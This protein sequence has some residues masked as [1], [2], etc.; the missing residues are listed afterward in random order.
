M[1]EYKICNYCKK[2]FSTRSNC[3]KHQK[4][5]KIKNKLQLE[6][7]IKKHSEKINNTL[8]E[9]KQINELKSMIADKDKQIEHRD[10]QIEF[11]K[12]IIE[13]YAKTPTT[14][15][16][17][18]P[19]NNT[20]NNSFTP[21]E[22]VSQLEPVDF[23]DIKN[24]MHL[25]TKDYIDQGVKGFAQ[26]LCDHPCREKIITTN[27]SRKTVAYRTKNMDFV[28]D[29]EATY[30][31]N[32][33]LKENSDVIINKSEERKQHYNERLFENEDSIFA[34]GEKQKINTIDFYEFL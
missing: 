9:I 17:Y 5:C 24:F 28:R 30:L 14:I 4:I 18:K 8:S 20:I 6:E 13:T 21:K 27:H 10:E 3:T 32:R 34:D 33:V 26:F 19:I 31:I 7:E 29:P 15:N 12:S 25:F 23:D 16:N 2:T 11:L 22:I 1:D